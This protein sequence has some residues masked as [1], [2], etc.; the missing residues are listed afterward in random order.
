MQDFLED[1]W[2]GADRVYLRGM[3]QA[4]QV[5]VNRQVARGGERLRAGDLVEVHGAPEDAEIPQ[6]RNRT[7]AGLEV[8]YE[9]AALLIV[10]KPAGIP[11]VP[12][13]SG[14]ERGVHGQLADLRP[15]DDLRI[16]HRLDRDTSG[17]LLLAKGLESA[18]AL[19]LAFREGRVRKRYLALVEGR[20]PSLEMVLERAL[21]PDP[22]RPGKVRVVPAESKGARSARTRVTVVE[23]F[24]RFTLVHAHPETG[25][26]HQIRVHLAAAHHPVVA[27][28]DYGPREPLLLS[29]LKAGFKLRPGLREKPLLPRMFLHAQRLELTSPAT[30]A[31]VIAECPLPA[32][33]E[34][35]LAKMRRFCAD[36]AQ[37]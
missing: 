14:K 13:R 36:E 9:D 27:D 23:R 19:D 26:S 16:V 37:R 18:R 4:G 2:P 22:R 33:L 12:D 17:C 21:G 25:R 7:P 28:R 24:T 30:G 15:G 5:L 8:L 34:L 10:A 20:L 31:E 29:Q 1:R 6:R 32:D 3:I 11:T 35:G